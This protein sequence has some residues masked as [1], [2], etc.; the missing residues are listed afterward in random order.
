MF[1]GKIIKVYLKIREGLTMKMARASFLLFS[2]CVAGL[3]SS[4][5]AGDIV[6]Y[7][8]SRVDEVTQRRVVEAILQKRPSIV[9]RVGDIVNDGHDPRQWEIFNNIR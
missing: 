5:F 3:F 4:A 9:F 2:L 6:V 1:S 8:D 7:G